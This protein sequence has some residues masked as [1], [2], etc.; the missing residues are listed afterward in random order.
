MRNEIRKKKE[1]KNS[2]LKM[3]MCVDNFILFQFQQNIQNIKWDF[4]VRHLFRVA[5]NG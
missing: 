1:K 4:M 2:L 5:A 3:R